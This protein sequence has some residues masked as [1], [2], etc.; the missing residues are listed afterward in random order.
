MMRSQSNNIYE[1]SKKGK[2]KGSNSKSSPLIPENK[3]LFA[4]IYTCGAHFI[5]LELPLSFDTT[6]DTQKR[7]LFEIAKEQFAA[8]NPT[9]FLFD[10]KIS[11]SEMDVDMD[12]NLT[13]F[14]S[15]DE[16]YEWKEEKERTA[17]QNSLIEE[18]E[19][20]EKIRTGMKCFLFLI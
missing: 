6:S 8:S 5:M 11:S 13:G 9:G 16:Y 12:G 14:M 15:C 18:D 10:W 17:I 19:R 3:R 20:N 2:R 7:A 1:M 4:K